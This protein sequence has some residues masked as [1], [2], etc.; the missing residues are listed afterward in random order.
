MSVRVINKLGQLDFRLFPVADRV[1]E[2]YS[3]RFSLN[4]AHCLFEQSQPSCQILGALIFTFFKEK[5]V[6]DFDFFCFA[7]GKFTTVPL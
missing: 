7:L 2:V 1:N 3:D 5:Y 4:R 6:S